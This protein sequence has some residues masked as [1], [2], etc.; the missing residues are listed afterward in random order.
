[1]TLALE[2]IAELRAKGRR[3]AVATLVAT[4]G[5]AIRRLGETMWVDDHGAIVGLHRAERRHF[6]GDDL[7]LLFAHELEDLAGG[8]FAEHER[9][10]PPLN[11]Q[12]WK[13]DREIRKILLDQVLLYEL[14]VQEESAAQ[15]VLPAYFEVAFGGARSAAKDPDSTDEPLELTRPTL[16]GD[17]AIKI[18]GQIDRVDVARDDTVVAYDYKLSTGASKVDMLSGRNL[19]LPIYLEALEKLILPDRPIAGGGYYII[20]GAKDRRNTGLYRT[21]HL[22]YVNLSARLKN[23]VLSDEEWQSVREIVIAKI[24]KFLDGMRAGRFIVD[25]S[26]GVKTC[27]F[28]EYGAVCRYSRDRIWR[29]KKS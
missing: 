19:Q 18:S 5:G 4:T 9:V 28:C 23:S 2:R 15:N 29:K 8:V 6:A 1:M 12:I 17:E 24:W 10:V 7:D 3:A 21:T 14:E 27:K 20:R 25:P 26:Q 16:I 22:D 11:K 13:I